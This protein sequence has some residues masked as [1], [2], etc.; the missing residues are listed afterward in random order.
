MYT[1]EELNLM[2][3]LEVIPKKKCNECLKVFPISDVF[4]LKEKRIKDGYENRCRKCRTG[5]YKSIHNSNPKNKPVIDPSIIKKF[6]TIEK[7]YDLYMEKNIVADKAFILDN[8]KE[9]FKYIISKENINLDDLKTLDRD[10]FKKYRLYSPLLKYYKGRIFDFINTVYPDLFNPWDFVTVGRQY[11]NKKEN[12]IAALKWF[13]NKLIKDKVIDSIDDLPLK[14]NGNNFF[15]YGLSGLLNIYYNHSYNAFNDLYPNKFYMWQYANLPVGYIEQK[16]YRIQFFKELVEYLNIKVSDIPKVLSY[17]Y[18]SNAYNNIENKV[19]LNKFK[20]IIDLYYKDLYEYVNEVYPNR[21]MREEFPYKNH[22]ITLDNMK[23]R[24]EPE[25]TIHHYF[26]SLNINFKYGDSV[27]RMNI[28]N[29][30][31]LPDWYIYKDDKIF[32]V[33]Y[34]GMLDMRHVDFGYNDKYDMKE[35][36]YNELCNDNN[37]YIYLPLHK[38]DLKNNLAGSKRKLIKY[39]LI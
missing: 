21:F 25:R 17:E 37:K 1:Q 3:G 16:K 8:H 35:K 23:V 28:N 13:V 36:L 14:I 9:I 4:F 2:E 18:L 39:K 34:Y 12:R 29:I 20:R 10:W 26:M 6:P 32:L 11:W 24:S 38:D 22:Y 15:D 19:Y 5:K 33:E 27:G 7:Q 30:N 31:V